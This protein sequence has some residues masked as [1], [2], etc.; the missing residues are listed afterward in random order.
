MYSQT[1]K[2]AVGIDCFAVGKN[3]LF[4]ALFGGRQWE[5]Y[6]SNQTGTLRLDVLKLQRFFSLG[7]NG[8]GR[9]QLLL[10]V[11]DSGS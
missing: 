8:C 11:V 3:S 1:Y 7:I 6:S 2:T 10:C 5:T 4:P 9:H